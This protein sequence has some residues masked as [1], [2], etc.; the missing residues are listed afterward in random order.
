MTDKNVIAGAVLAT[1]IVAL[2]VAI[3][4]LGLFYM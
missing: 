4:V 1:L 3:V 2:L